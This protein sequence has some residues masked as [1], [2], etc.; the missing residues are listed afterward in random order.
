MME[1]KNQSI[2]KNL[3]FF[4]GIIVIIGLIFVFKGQK[5][6][7]D[8]N[9]QSPISTPQS[10]M[11][12]LT[13]IET[14]PTADNYV[15]L[16]LAYYNESKIEKAIEATQQAILINPND[17]VAYNNLGWYYNTLK[18]WDRAI[19]AFNTVLEINPDFDLASRNLDIAITNKENENLLIE[20][21]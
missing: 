19:E 15:T 21:N 9:D 13:A 14:N 2:L 12:S 20:E 10:I 8:D 17:P 18:E 16:G 7:V 4:V 3:Y 1:Q 5:N 11:K 6:S